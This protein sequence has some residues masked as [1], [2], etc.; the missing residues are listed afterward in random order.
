M[1]RFDRRMAE[2][3]NKISDFEDRVNKIMKKQETKK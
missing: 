1:V 2:A 3:E